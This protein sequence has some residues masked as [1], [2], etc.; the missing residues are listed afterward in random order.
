MF[1][2]MMRSRRRGR[3]TKG[4]SL[5][6][7]I[8]TQVQHAWATAVELVGLITNSQPK[9]PGNDKRYEPSMGYASEVLARA[10]EN[11]KSCHPELGDGEIVRKFLELNTDLGL[12][13]LLRKLDPS[14]EQVARSRNAILILKEGKPLE[15]KAFRY[16]TDA[17]KAL[18]EIEAAQPGTDVV[19]VKGDSPEDV[20]L[21]FRNYFSDARDFIKLIE[22]GCEKLSGRRV[23]IAIPNPGAAQAKAKRDI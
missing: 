3:N 22:D 4:Y 5:S 23:M 9:F 17:L 11:A 7:S 21:A 19:L 6:Y 13:D 2:S 10:Y 15:I 14:D 18:F 16:S 1:T 12:L 20:R 8:G